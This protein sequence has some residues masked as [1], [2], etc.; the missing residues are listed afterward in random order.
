[1]ANETFT[2]LGLMSGTSMDGIDVALIDSDG[3]TI[4]S[5][6][7]FQSFAYTADEQAVLRQGVAAAAGLRERKSRPPALLRA[8]Q[9]VTER[10]GEAVLAFLSELGIAREEVAIVGFHGQTV[11][12]RP[13]LGLTIQIGDGQALSKRIG[14]PVVY[15][16][17]A[18]D[19]VHG[20][21]GAPLVPVFHQAL[22][23]SS[24]LPF[25][26]I[27]MNVG[28]VANITYLESADAVPLAC[29]VGP[30]GALLDDFMLERTGLAMDKDG[31][32]AAAGRIDAAVLDELLA[33]PFFAVEPPKSLDRNT[34]T[35]QAVA[36]LSTV[37]GAATLTAFTARAAGRIL[38]FLPSPPKTLIV[39]GGGAYNPTLR[40]MLSRSFSLAALSADDIGWSASALEA[41]AFAYLAIRARLELALTFPT[42]TGVSAPVSGGEF[43]F[44]GA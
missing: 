28:G 39:A 26:L 44:P 18:R 38:G 29:D 23:R 24:G 6:G 41:Q 9:L 10:H 36:R 35:R 37:D 21:E 2:A 13:E 15:D 25:P 5:F 40:A 17:R 8:E 16:F 33:H 42:T 34:M 7:P 14:I 30:G 11:L 4:S 22:A 1:M 20:G 31:A 19:M 3:E 43:A 32:A 12:H 27:V